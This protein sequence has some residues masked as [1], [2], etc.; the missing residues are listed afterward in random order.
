MCLPVFVFGSVQLQK[1]HPHTQKICPEKRKCHGIKLLPSQSS[2][3]PKIC[4]IFRYLQGFLPPKNIIYISVKK[5]LKIEA[6]IFINFT[7][8]FA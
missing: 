5:K 8:I 2:T 7:R 1:K 4:V 6:L 3:T